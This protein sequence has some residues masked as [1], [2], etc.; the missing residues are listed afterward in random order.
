MTPLEKLA[1]LAAK[2]CSLSIEHNDH[3]NIYQPV[4]AWLTDMLETED[5][6]LIDQQLCGEMIAR[7]SVFWIQWYPET[8]IGFHRVFHWDLEQAINLAWEMS[9]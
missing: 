7:D 1:A 3:H 4:A 2:S 9:Q 8:P 5:P 6:A